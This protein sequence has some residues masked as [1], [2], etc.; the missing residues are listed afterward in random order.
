MKTLKT[1]PHVS[2]IRLSS[3]SIL[4]SLL[5]LQFKTLSDLLV[6]YLNKPQIARCNDK[7]NGAPSPNTGIQTGMLN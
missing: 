4:C 6:C 7:D 1:L 2:I 3:G 5:K